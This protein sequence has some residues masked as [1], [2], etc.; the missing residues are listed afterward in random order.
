MKELLAEYLDQFALLHG[1]PEIM[2]IF[3]QS[4]EGEVSEAL[5]QLYENENEKY[6]MALAVYILQLQGKLDTV[7]PETGA[8]GIGVDV[9]ASVAS[10]KIHIKRILG[11]ISS[12]EVINALK[13]IAKAALTI[14]IGLAIGAAAY[15]VGKITFIMATAI[16]GCGIIGTIIAMVYTANGM[17]LTHIISLYVVPYSWIHNKSLLF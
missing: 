15:I 4:I 2:E 1:E 13:K 11:K 5:L 9:A 3:F 10:A 7:P 14:M 12:Q 8:E 6:Y 16:F 17:V